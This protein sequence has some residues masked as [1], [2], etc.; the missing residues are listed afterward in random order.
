MVTLMLEQQISISL[1]AWSENERKSG[2]ALT[3]LGFG[4]GNYNDHLMQKIAQ[5]G[6]GNAAYIDTI[7][8]ARKVLVEE[9]GATLQIIAKDMKIQIEFNPA[10]VETYRLIG[11]ETRHL[12]REDFNNDKI[13]AGEVGAG[14]TVTALYE[15]TLIGESANI[16]DPLRYSRSKKQIEQRNNEELAFLKLRYKR[17]NED[18]SRLIEH[19]LYARDIV[20]EIDD[21]SEI[22]KFS[23][24]V[25]WFGQVLRNN[26]H[27]QN[28]SVQQIV[29]LALDA[30]GSDNF[31]YR[32]E[33]INLARTAKEL[34]VTS[35]D[36]PTPAPPIAQ[37][38]SIQGHKL[39]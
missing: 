10:V 5:I 30:R 19:P 8:E 24:A 35:V 22:Y 33:F 37:T 29:D 3:V 2:I 32:S 21:T 23:A 15:L 36:L 34:A 11:Y 38:S 4:S 27:V 18:T 17:P 28:N 9:L 31:G 13:D 16:A 1:N 14:H 39:R 12:E 26:K 7:N 6:N 20:K 25:A